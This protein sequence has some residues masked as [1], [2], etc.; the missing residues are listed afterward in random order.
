MR[1][2]LL[3]LRDRK[4]RLDRSDRQGPLGLPVAGRPDRKAQQVPPVLQALQDNKGLRDL[5]AVRPVKSVPR[6]N[7][8][9]PDPLADRRDRS[10]RRVRKVSR[11]PQASR[12]RRGSL[13]K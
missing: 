2:A 11:G 10:V 7:K 8:E 6:D 4:G 9:S 3:A 5:R 12:E 1:L 13:G